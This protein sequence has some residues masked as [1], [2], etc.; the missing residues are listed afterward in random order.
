MVIRD[1]DVAVVQDV[2]DLTSSQH[3]VDRDEHAAGPRRAEDRG[4]GLDPLV[5]V[6]PDPITPMYAEAPEPVRHCL[7]GG[8]EFAVRERRALVRECRRVA[9]LGCLLFDQVV[10]ERAHLCFLRDRQPH[11][12]T[13]TNS[14]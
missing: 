7:D 5:E 4:D 13:A 10:D 11:Q 3:G 6:D 9:A 12:A 8:P 1:P 2:T 14:L